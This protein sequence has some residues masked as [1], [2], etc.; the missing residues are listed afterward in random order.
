VSYLNGDPVPGDPDFVGPVLAWDPYFVGPQDDNP[1]PGNPDFVGPVQT[2]SGG[3]SS[4]S[5]LAIGAAVLLAGG[6]LGAPV[7]R[8]R[9]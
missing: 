9:R 1:Q 8:R 7:R 5:W 6:I 3:S 4:F 2:T